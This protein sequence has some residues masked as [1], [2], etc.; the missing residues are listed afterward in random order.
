MLEEIL[1]EPAEDCEK[2][3]LEVRIEKMKKVLSSIARFD[4]MLMTYGV[5]IQM[6]NDAKEAL[7]D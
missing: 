2:T 1:H 4:P 7:K 3:H 6:V 5:A